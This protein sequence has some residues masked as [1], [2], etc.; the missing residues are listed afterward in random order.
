MGELMLEGMASAQLAG[1][2]WI[3]QPSSAKSVWGF[4]R[5]YRNANFNMPLACRSFFEHAGIEFTL[6]RPWRLDTGS[7]L[8]F[9]DHDTALDGFALPMACPENLALKRVIFAV[10]GL[11]LGW[12]FCKRNLPVYPKGSYRNLWLRNSGIWDRLVYFSTHRWGPF[13]SNHAAVRAI[14]ASLEQGTSVSMLP[15]GVVGRK[16]WRSGV[17]AVLQECKG[18]T[19]SDSPIYAAP[20][21][22]T[23]DQCNKPLR[24]HSPGLVR[25]DHLREQAGAQATRE[26]VT[27]WLQ[28]RY[29]SRNWI[30]EA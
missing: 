27:K 11:A 23:W 21:Y 24:V 3:L 17:G 22:L 30:F 18:N 2:K 9:C 29:E 6:D 13:A 12:E 25:F 20:V 7:V 28:Q 16:E 1:I 8:Y 19:N 26:T 15:S 14:C 4:D 10:S 5:I